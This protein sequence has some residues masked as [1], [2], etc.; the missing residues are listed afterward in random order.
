M[1]DDPGIAARRQLAEPTSLRRAPSNSEVFVIGVV[2]VAVLYFARDVFIPLALAVLLAF[3]LA[4]AV[5]L[6]R[7]WHF[8]RILSVVCVVLLAAIVIAGIG[9]VVGTQLAQLAENLPGYQTN[10]ITKIQ[11]LRSSGVGGSTIERT[12]AM[13]QKLGDEIAKSDAPGAAALAAPGAGTKQNPVPVEIR[14]P[15]PTPLRILENAVGPLLQPLATTGIVIIFVIFVLLQREDLRDRFIRLAGRADLHRTTDAL[16][17]A[18]QRISRYLLVQVAINTCFGILIGGGLWLIGAP[19]PVLCG[20]VAMLLRFVP[21]VGPI[22]AAALPAALTL[23]VDPGWTMLFWAMGLFLTA[24]LITGQIVE[25]W[26]YGHN[27]GLSTIAI[28]VAAAFWTWLWGPVGLLLSTPLTVC[29]VVL[30]R[31][32]EHLQFLDVLLGDQPALAPEESFY[33]RM[34]AGDPDEAAHQAEEMLKTVPLATYYDEV[35]VK[36][37]ALAQ[38]DVN[39]GALDHECRVRIKDAVDGLI[40]DLSDHADPTPPT[41]K[42]SAAKDAPATVPAPTIFGP[43]ELAPDWRKTPVMCIAGRGSLDEAAAAMLAQLLAA[44]GIAASV[45]SSSVVSA[46]NLFR[47]DGDG[48]QV[49]CLS[50]LEPGGYTN[51]RFLARRLRRKLPRATILVGFWSLTEAEAADAQQATGADGVVTSLRLAVAQ[52]VEAAQAAADRAKPAEA[53]AEPAVLPAAE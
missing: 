4:P 35:A 14:E 1:I 18:A 25:P 22:I 13:L 33:Q 21:Y 36:G 17:E 39:R 9:T 8:N 5:L 7:R 47:L 44:R 52:V 34:L 45:V 51:A 40:D 37:L 23:A 28:V 6:L 24:E 20:I 30:G 38:L 3:A 2:V 12:S 10:I 27:T 42:E 26:L 53:A 46:G 32:V 41:A 48:V 16:D 31:H 49:A 15:D 29:L 43:D 50:Y 19:N 11:A